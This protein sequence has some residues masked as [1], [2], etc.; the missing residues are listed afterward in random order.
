MARVPKQKCSAFVVLNFHG[1]G[2]L[3]EN[4]SLLTGAIMKKRLRNTGL[5]DSNGRIFLT[6]NGSFWGNE[7]EM[8]CLSR[9]KRSYMLSSDCPL[10]DLKAAVGSWVTPS[11]AQ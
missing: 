4:V 9:R 7:L 8:C 1:E 5:D 3:R 2:E 10:G 11:A 6:T